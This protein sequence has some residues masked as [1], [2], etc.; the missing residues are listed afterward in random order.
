[1][2]CNGSNE[3][4]LQSVNS[5]HSISRACKSANQPLYT[6]VLPTSTFL[7][8][9]YKHTLHLTRKTTKVMAAAM[10]RVA[11]SATMMA[12]SPLQNTK[13]RKVRVSEAAAAGAAVWAPMLESWTMKDASSARSWV[14]SRLACVCTFNARG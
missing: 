5:V 13:L 11:A 7:L 10:A 12:P 14:L 6:K 1:M 9:M 3:G 2:S 4:K 8:P